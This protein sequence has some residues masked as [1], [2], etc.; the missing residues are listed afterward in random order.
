MAALEEAATPINGVTCVVPAFNAASTIDACLA[1]LL[2]QRTDIELEVIV[3]DDGSEDGTAALVQRWQ[4][5]FAQLKMSLRVIR[6]PSNGGAARARNAGIEQASYDWILTC[7][8]DDTSRPNRVEALPRAAE[9]TSDARNTLFG[10]RFSRNPPNATER[11]ATWA[12]ALPSERLFLE[13]FRECTLIQP[14]WFFHRDLWRNAGRYD[15]DGETCDD[16]RFFLR[17]VGRGGLLHRVEED[18]VVYALSE[19]LSSIT[20]RKDL[21]KCRVAAFSTQIL[22]GPWRGRKIHVWGA[23]RDGRCFLN[24]LALIGRADAVEAL[25]DVDEAK[26]GRYHNGATGLSMPVRH[27]DEIRTPF[28][29]C[30]SMRNPELVSFV[31]AAAQRLGA[32]EGADYFHFN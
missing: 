16:L 31:R 25:Y 27:V 30:V 20:H 15:D 12:N 29:V 26:I 10:S 28:V 14:T 24:E 18:L 1:S 8:A 22:D 21:V 32:A 23:G 5:R 2:A 17:H 6:Q 9:R 13:R 19:G 11:Y 7:D 4:A 3:V